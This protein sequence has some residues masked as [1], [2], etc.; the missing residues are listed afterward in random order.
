[1]TDLSKD[2]AHRWP[3]RVPDGLPPDLRQRLAT[4]ATFATPCGQGWTVWRQ[5]RPDVSAPA[6]APPLVLLHGGSGSWTHWALNIAALLDAGREVWVPDLPGFGASDSPPE[7]GDADALVEPLADGWTRLGASR[8]AD[9][10]GFSFGGMT[11]GM[12]AAAQPALVR[13]LLLVGAPAMGVVPARQFQLRAW[14]HLPDVAAQAS[15]HQHNLAALMFHDP[16]RIDALAMEIHVENVWRDRMPRRRLS[17]TDILA[18]TLPGVRCPVHAIYGAHD[19]LYRRYIVE[20]KAAFAHVTPDFRGL[21]LV[22]DAGHWVQ[23]EAAAAFNEVL[24]AVL[25]SPPQ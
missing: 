19:A 16:T 11:A 1:M 22:P 10:V 2:P 17:A 4:A 5:W 25:E 14:R 23:Y 3:L 15:V 18:R 6:G 7:G 13:R 12:L 21:T 20:L 9:W 24:A 8:P